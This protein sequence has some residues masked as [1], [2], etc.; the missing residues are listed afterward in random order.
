MEPL[1]MPGATYQCI[2]QVLAVPPEIDV[3]VTSSADPGVRLATS[4][5]ACWGSVISPGLVGP[6]AN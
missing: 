6:A 4:F 1:M 5:H 3:S 2:V